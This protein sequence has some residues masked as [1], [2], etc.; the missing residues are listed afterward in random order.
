MARKRIFGVLSV[1]TVQGDVRAAYGLGF[2]EHPFPDVGR[3]CVLLPIRTENRLHFS[4]R[5]DEGDPEV[6]FELVLRS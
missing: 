3:L 5:L 1:R 2:R 4:V 6:R